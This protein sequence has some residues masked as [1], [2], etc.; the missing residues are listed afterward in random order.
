M[1]EAQAQREAAIRAVCERHNQR[2]KE[3]LGAKMADLQMVSEERDSQVAHAVSAARRSEE[4][5]QHQKK[6]DA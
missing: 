3:E 1:S 4:L 5:Q 6:A 2:L